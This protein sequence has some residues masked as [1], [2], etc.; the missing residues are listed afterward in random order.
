MFFH[1]FFPIYYLRTEKVYELQ[2]HIYSWRF[3]V[4]IMLHSTARAHYILAVLKYTWHGL[5]TYNIVEYLLCLVSKLYIYILCV[6]NGLPPCV[7]HMTLWF[8][9]KR[10]RVAILLIYLPFLCVKC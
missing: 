5:F 3:Q 4:G 6:A 2:K 7:S 9:H 8:V 1:L 10:A